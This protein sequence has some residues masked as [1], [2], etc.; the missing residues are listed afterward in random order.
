MVLRESL[1]LHQTIEKTAL[2][3]D[4]HVALSSVAGQPGVGD[5]VDRIAALL[6]PLLDAE[7]VQL[8]S[9]RTVKIDSNGEIAAIVQLTLG[10]SKFGSKLKNQQRSVI[11]KLTKT[12]PDNRP[13]AST[14][15]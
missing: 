1:P 3:Q 7:L 11:F 10:I 12:G 14:G 6:V 5:F 2:G 8:G 4:T 15:M 9:D 13:S